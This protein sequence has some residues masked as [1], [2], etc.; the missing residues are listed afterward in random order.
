MA[1]CDPSI[2]NDIANPTNFSAWVSRVSADISRISSLQD[3]TI[4]DIN[5]I[6]YTT[7]QDIKDHQDCINA[8]ANNSANVLANDITN[9]QNLEGINAAIEKRSHDVTISY[10]RAQTARNPERNR[11]Y[12]DG[13][14]PISR[15]LKHYTI[16][17]LIALSLFL[18]SLSLFYL[19]SLF[20]F[21]MAFMI[22]LPP[23][24]TGPLESY[25]N[26]SLYTSKPFLIM[27]AIAVVLLGLTIYGFIKK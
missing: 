17:I 4:E 8:T 14:F 6:T 12:Y 15:P 5:Y 22:A 11:G 24:I 26:K 19:L 3:P 27:T 18:F 13:W 2:Q 9:A 23:V 7:A 1:L 25:G 16:P 20:G 10:E 21:N